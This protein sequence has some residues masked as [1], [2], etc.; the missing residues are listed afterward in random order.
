GLP[1]PNDLEAALIAGRIIAYGQGFA[2]MAAASEAFDWGLDLARI[3]EI[4]RAGCIIRSAMLDDIAAAF[5]FGAPHGQLA[6]TPD[7]VARLND[8]VPALRRVTAAAMGPG[9]PVPAMSAAL[10]WFDTM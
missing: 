7:F 10:A 2:L 6:F 8:A 5:R 4:W 3:A 1:G 9:L